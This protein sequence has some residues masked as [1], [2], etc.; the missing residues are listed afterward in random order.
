MKRPPAG[1]E[2]ARFLQR[3]A[4]ANAGSV[5]AYL[6][7]LSLLLPARLEELAGDDR[8]VWLA[9]A[10]LGGA[11]TASISNIAF[12]MLS[13]R[14]GHRRPWIAAGLALTLASFPLLLLAESP[15]QIVVAVILF[16][17]ALNLLLAP[18]AAL[19]ADR[20]AT[21][22]DAALGARL[23]GRLALAQ[24]AAALVGVIV[25]L[26]FL[27][28]LP[29]Q[30]ALIGALAAAMLLPLLRAA[31]PEATP[32]CEPTPP[33]DRLGPAR[34]R[35]A[36]LWLSRLLVQVAGSTLFAF[37][38]VYFQSL[39]GP[40]IDAARVAMVNAAALAV[41]AP[42][43]LLASRAAQSL[44]SERLLLVA[45]A[46]LMA[47]GLS[48]MALQSGFGLSA[49]G[50]ALFV[51]ALNCY[52]ALHV[53]YAMRHL[54]SPGRRGLGLALFNLTNTL[55]SI[56]AALLTIALVPSHQFRGLM[57]VLAALAL[58]AALLVAWV[59][60]PSELP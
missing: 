60:S 16:Q 2:D 35:L 22:P 46:A 29:A 3:F 28:G 32:G 12:G 55:P 21:T 40:P 20:L 10:T 8:I 37:L 59:R 41:A 5:V 45:T 6:P 36:L 49:A 23:G 53:V 31:E 39:P 9:L 47:V 26:P 33:P 30:M 25:T 34:R 24:P 43:A 17:A 11:L 15:P 4:L 58:L 14:S 56:F 18:L 57:L 27:P 42:L 1:V 7:L 50:Y 13:D 51:A 44:R 52:L 54:P 38:L 48:L 19:A